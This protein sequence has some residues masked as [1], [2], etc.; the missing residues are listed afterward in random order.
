MISGSGWAWVRVRGGWWPGLWREGWRVVVCFRDMYG[1]KVVIMK[2]KGR[3]D[4]N[5]PT[6]PN[7][8]VHV[9]TLYYYNI[10]LIETKGQLLPSHP[11]LQPKLARRGN[12]IL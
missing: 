7:K 11:F 3:T 1:S 2:Y 5:S 8:A 9:A 4:S 10:Y 12:N 6:G